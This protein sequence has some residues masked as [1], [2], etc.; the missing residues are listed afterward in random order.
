M[1]T[2]PTA[3]S[4]VCRGTSSGLESPAGGQE[5]S[6]RPGWGGGHARGTLAALSAALVLFGTTGEEGVENEAVPVRVVLSSPSATTAR[7]VGNCV[8]GVSW[9]IRR[10][11]LAYE[12]ARIV[13][14]YRTR[15]GRRPLQLEFGLMRSASWKAQHMARFYYIAHFDPAPPVDRSPF[16]R[17]AACGFSG[18]GGENIAYG[19]ETAHGVVRAWLRS[20]GHRRNIE[21]PSWRYTG[22]G[23]AT[24]REGGTFWAQNFG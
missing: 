11:Q 17:I 24:S 8:A 7:A 9:G 1:L 21:N 23:V 12:V 5:H 13:N 19:F 14:T 4:A 6:V 10:D 18:G 22:V 20:P 3:T 16:E 15:I 2:G